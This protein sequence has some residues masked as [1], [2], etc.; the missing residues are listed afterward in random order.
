MKKFFLIGLY[1]FLALPVFAKHVTG[2][3][4]IYNYVGPGEVANTKKYLITLRLFRDDNT[5]GGALLP[6]TLVVSVFNNDDNSNIT[7]YLNV[8]RSS[9]ETLAIISSPNC[10]TSPPA[11]NYSAGYYSFEVNL[12]ANSSGYTA[13]YQTCCRIDGITNTSDMVGAT[14]VG[15]IPGS[16]TL[17][18][19]NDNSA[20]FTTGISII[21]YNKPF[22]LDFSATDP[23]AGDSLVYS[24]TDAYNGGAATSSGFA[25]PAAPAYSSIPYTNPYTGGGP[26]GPTATINTATGIISGIA[27]NAGKYVVCVLVK[28]YRNGVFIANH[29]KDF[30]V[31]VA[32]CDFASSVLDPVYT[33]CESLTSVF[34]NNNTSLL[35][36]T[37][38]WD[39]GD[40]ASGVN[41]TSSMEVAPHTF[42]AAGDYTI[43]LTV[44]RGA[45]CADSATAL[46]KVYP[47]FYPA[48]DSVP[49]HC[50]NLPVVFRDATTA[51]Y[52]TV[53][54]WHWNFGETTV[55]ND[56]SRLQNP[57]YVYPLTGTKN[58][59]LIVETSKGCRDTIYREVMIVEKPDL[60]LT[61]DTLICTIDTLRL[62]AISN[63][64]GGTISWS[65]NYMISDIHSFTPDIS[66]DVPT[67][68]TAFFD[69]G[70]GCTTSAS[71]FV[72]VA[73]NV[74]ITGPKD[75]TIC[76]TDSVILKIPSTNALY[77]LWTA[78]PAA[79]I[80]D[81]LT[82]N[83]SVLP[84]APVTN[85]NVRAS[86]SKKCF[87]NDLV[88]VTT[89][90]YPVA[91]AT[92]QD[93]VCFGK[94][95]QLFAS[96]GSLYTWA[97]SSY[98][99]NPLIANPISQ[100]PRASVLYQVSVR[101]T[102][103]CPKPS[104]AFF[105][106]NVI[107]INADAGPQDTSVV[108]EQPLQLFGTGG[109]I[110]SWT[111]A[112]WLTNA[113]IY[114]PI[115]NPQNTIT[116]TLRVSNSIGCFGEDTI[117]VKVF[118][119]PPDVYVPSA[120]TP[121][122]DKLNDVF[123][124]IALGIKSLEN[125]SVF[126]RWGELLYS[127]KVIGQGWDGTFKGRPQNAGTYV[128]EVSCTDF[129]NKTIRRKGSVILIK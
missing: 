76:R 100:A 48:F 51:N 26:F 88:T 12:P 27:P 80:S 41:N 122:T 23:D 65:P 30:I 53:N 70:F 47:G 119:V 79:G 45:A 50:V 104:V 38:D 10:L 17:S 7:G 39:F 49:P 60:K 67:R 72:N 54:Y 56:T 123:R 14:Y 71:V 22:R 115:S 116:Y 111:P 69:D 94:N 120:F 19:G 16:N 9:Q 24:F 32:D 128:W 124:P 6:T 125:F 55:T 33:N 117:R 118:F 89:V 121:G 8:N 64:S 105:K 109:S 96:G 84:T 28:S 78:I 31:T 93:T 3:E 61:N 29:R 66:P 90:P 129:R 52:G 110:F 57:T 97:P 36:L 68:Y 112:T 87:T 114:N 42:S 102:L 98:L 18:S 34:R 126:N 20:R 95:V 73:T 83:P 103:G 1:F 108:L 62:N 40:P 43:K 13:T 81:S 74:N 106:V 75:T 107:K 127:T 92:G 99:N 21:C 25:Q 15:E 2:G 4:I 101:D 85:F 35:N 11:L 58:V 63:F 86:I 77:F 113:N 37:F 5:I 59:E 44:N 46:V 91:K 82:K